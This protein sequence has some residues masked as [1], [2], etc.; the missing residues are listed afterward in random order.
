[1]FGTLRVQLKKVAEQM[2]E[3]QQ[4][5]KNPVVELDVP[6]MPA[7]LASFRNSLFIGDE[8]GN[9]T[10]AES[11]DDLKVKFSQK[12]SFV[13]ITSIAVNQTYLALSFADL[14]KENIK[15]I[16][17]KLKIKK[18]EH[19]N[20]VAIYRW[21]SNFN[22]DKIISLHKQP[23]VPGG[24]VA[25]NS[26]ALTAANELFVLD[27]ELQAILKIDARSGELMK[28]VTFHESELTAISL[29]ANFLAAVDSRQHEVILFDL[30]KLERINSMTINDE[31]QSHN[32]PYDVV[33]KQNNFIFV[34]SRSDSRVMIYDFDLNFKNIF[35][36][37]NS[38]FQGLNI[39]KSAGGSN[40][41]LL[42]GKNVDNK[43]FKLGYFADF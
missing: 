4:L 36:Y 17:K 13:N 39:M 10:L 5:F 33:I 24:L 22:F 16:Y 27:K 31:F 26:V 2:S 28:K 37:E 6:T 42:I 32:G 43:H 35:E 14:S 23:D 40:E 7:Y 41:M 30:I 8:C 38:S 20:G 11:N 34:K 19:K 9:L 12:L 1:M 21:E 29:G 25:P 3:F 15:A 18:F